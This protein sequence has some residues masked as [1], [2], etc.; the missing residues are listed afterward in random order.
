MFT[1]AAVGTNDLEQAKQFYDAVLGALGIANVGPLGDRGTVYSDG[2]YKFIVTKPV[3]GKPATSANGGTIGFSAPSRAAVRKFHE[4]GLANG[5]TDEGKPGPRNVGPHA[6][7][8]YLRDPTGNKI[9]AFCFK[10]EGQGF[11]FYLDMFFIPLII[12]LGWIA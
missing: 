7:G 1:H 5:G 9:V 2:A 3:N 11:S 8:A 4:A 6:Y 12:S 10:D